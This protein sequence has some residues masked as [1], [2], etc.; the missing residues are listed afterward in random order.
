MI[1]V[2][3]SA[4]SLAVT[5]PSFHRSHEPMNAASRTHPI[6]RGLFLG[7]FAFLFALSGWFLP[8]CAGQSSSA[9][10]AKAGSGAKG[11]VVAEVNGQPITQEE[12]EVS[13]AAQLRQLDQQRQTIL[14]QALDRLVDQ[15]LVELEASKRGSSTDD[16]MNA[17]VQSKIGT[18]SDA[19]VDSWYEQNKARINRPKEQVAAQIR[20]LLQQQRGSEVYN[21][22]IK[23]LKDKYKVRVLL[24]PIRTE[25]ATAGEPANGPDTAPV[26]I[27]E[28]SDFQCP[29]CG[30][31]AP[32]I[33][34]VKKN[35]GDK[36]RVVFR[37]FPLPMH[38]NASKAAEASL[39][40]FEQGKFW[41]MHD[42]MFKDQQK[43]SVPELKATA[44]TLGLDADKFNSCLDSGKYASKVQEDIDAG[45][46]VGVSGT[47]AMFV[48]GRFING[49]VPYEQVSSVIDDELSRKADKVSMK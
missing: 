35:Y 14:E 48:N 24:E 10:A 47:P 19:D 27:V 11:D 12:L 5:D 43:L 36:V 3:I 49:A 39:C 25:V 29:F 1:S 37:Q 28:F 40:A 30:R 9:A 16:L 20:Q 44:A 4:P 6:P 31:L 34:E 8:A 7:L 22:F 17:E 45:R 42:A 15:K 13:A 21:T 2:R 23:G 32:T 46:K 18:I 41:Q 26:T 33:D 38:P